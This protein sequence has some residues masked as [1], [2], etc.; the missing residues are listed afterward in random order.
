MN[1][2]TIKKASLNKDIKNIC[3]EKNIYSNVATLLLFKESDLKIENYVK[4]AKQQIF[5][6]YWNFLSK[7]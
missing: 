5:S 2:D 7:G 1:Y 3:K 6:W 4:F